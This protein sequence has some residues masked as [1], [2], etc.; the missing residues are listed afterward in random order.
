MMPLH[1]DASWL[2]VLAEC[3]SVDEVQAFYEANPEYWRITH[4]HAPLPEEAAEGFGFRP[5]TEMPYRDWQ[6]WLVRDRNSRR[7][8]GELSVAIDLLAPGVF[9]LGFFIIE[10]ARQGSGFAG[11]VHA[12]YEAWAVTQGARW[13]RLGVVAA[14]KRAEAFWRRRGYIEVKRREGYT[15]GTL[16]H[17]LIVMAKPVPPN[18]LADFLLAVPRDRPD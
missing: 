9:H 16:T 3:S 12:A 13:L 14:N 4:G 8:V 1:A 10:S 18:T 5:P 11:E 2:A 17:Q 6:I 7:I 15:L